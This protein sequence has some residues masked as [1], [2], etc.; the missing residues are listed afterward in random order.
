[1]GPPE[2]CTSLTAGASGQTVLTFLVSNEI[3]TRGQ[4]GTMLGGCVNP[5]GGLFSSCDPSN[6]GDGPT[7]ATVIFRTQVLDEFVD[8]Y[9]SG[10]IS[11]DQGDELGNTA[12]ITGDVLDN[13]TF[14]VVGTE[15]DNAAAGAAIG[16]ETLS[17]S[18]YAI[19]DI[20]N[21]AL[22]D[23]DGLGRVR[24]K[25]G[26]KITYRL[27][28]GL[29]TSDVEELTFDDYFPLPVF[30]V[31]DPDDDGLIGP[32]WSFSSAGGIPTPGVVTL[33]LPGDTFYQYMTD[34]LIGT[35][36]TL[37]AST[38][39]T[40]PT[41]EP[42]IVANA[43][44][45]KINIYFADYDDTRNQSTTVD[46]L[47]SLV[48]S[49]DPFAD[50]LFLT[51]MAHA[52]E[53]STN[54]GTNTENAI[55]QFVLGEPVLATTKGIV[56]TSN[57][58]P[59][60]VFDPT[61]IAPAGVNF[62]DPSNMPRWTGVINSSGLD[63][64]PI[65]S[66]LAGVDAGDTVTFA[67]TIENQGSS[68][69]GAFDIQLRDLI[70]TD[71]YIF[72]LTGADLNLQVYYGDRSGPI[73]YKSVELSAGIPV[74]TSG[75][76]PDC[77]LELFEEGIEFIDPAESNPALAG[78]CSA[79]DPN[80]GNN[81][82]LV[83]YDL[84]L[85]PDVIPG[86]AINTA[87]VFNYPGTEGGPNHL[88]GVDDLE[89]DATVD[90]LGGLEKTLDGTEF[91][92]PTNL[93][94]EV[95]IGELVTYTLTATIPE[96]NVP[97]A[98]LEDHLD[99]GLAFVSCDSVLIT[100]D[101]GVV[102]DLADTDF[103]GVCAATES[104]G[105]SNAGQDIVF[106]LG[107]ISNA[108]RDD[109]LERISITYTVVVTNVIGNQN[110]S[111]TVLNNQ[112]DFLMDAGTGDESLGTVSADEVTVIEPQV[113][114]EKFTPSG[115]TNTSN[116]GDAGDPVSYTINLINPS[117]PADTI[118]YEMEFIDNFPMCP[119]P[120]DGSAVLDLGI[121]SQSGGATFVLTG[122]NTNGWVLS[123]TYNGAPGTPID[124]VP[125]DSATVDLSG[126]IAYCV[127]PSLS[128]DNTGTTTW[129]SLSG[130]FSS[131]S[132][133]PFNPDAVERTGVDGVGGLLNDYA[134]EGTA[135]VMID[136]PINAKYLIDTSEL[137][138][139]FVTNQENV[140]IGEIVRYRVVTAIPE[141]TSPNFQIRDLL[142]QGLVFMNDNTAVVA[143]VSD[144]GITSM[145]VGIVPGI[146]DGPTPPGPDCNQTGSSADASTPVLD[147]VNC[148]LPDFNIGSTSS[149]SAN[150]DI[151][152][153]G[154]D[155]RFKLG[156]LVNTDSD[157]DTEYV[158]IEFNALV[159]N[160]NGDP[161]QNDSSENR[162]NSARIQI[163]GRDNGT[164]SNAVV[165]NIAEPVITVSKSLVAPLPVDAGDPIEYEIIFTNSD[166]TRNGATAFD[167]DL[168]DTFD[169]YLENVT[170]SSVSTTQAAICAGDGAGTTVFSSSQSLPPQ[171]LGGTFNSN[172]KLSG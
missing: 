145:G 3:I 44:D 94:D 162:N 168:T 37:S 14:T 75:V 108:D 113:V 125:G 43:S 150:F 114:T 13:S 155:L 52:F 16:R 46:L 31:T 74:C 65:D 33:M 97:N 138:T 4:N 133:S 88:D 22:W 96:G 95:V 54:A 129:T 123:A 35:T 89:D 166:T 47:F 124:F 48:V 27:T 40:V 19:N 57:N 105:I 107:T 149:T 132:R 23:M 21:S 17:K 90:V 55:I 60:A 144:S 77:G 34:G 86:Q 6:L 11:V 112:A 8:N 161:Q 115:S 70:D 58:N 87:T 146:P 64:D 134:S 72:P 120:T 122:D 56:W 143:F 84:E 119:I 106:N 5:A 29:L 69:R 171:P 148:T 117:T 169:N 73:D 18:I 76:D 53:G 83:T 79:H 159:S 121:D 151:Y 153:P 59:A 66:N 160:I 109:D 1:M 98:R 101:T 93:S 9:P 49:D 158:V 127:T 167:L 71:Y 130:D 36:G 99:S 110:T 170:I 67:I 140:A 92:T 39:N 78:V 61:Q 131:S 85:K 7:T 63:S 41:Q 163:N 15:S 28:Y 2:E 51:N 152:T 103:S 135:S 172:I 50:G 82:I 118:A 116:T 141:G 128:M 147:P 30:D 26:D 142:G 24:V 62:L 137:H 154:I 136:N 164:D 111:P 81:V 32:S 42:V 126:T 139:G 102:T 12:D 20:S 104:T 25:P 68:I 165:V 156:T 157:G 45:N 10:D 91:N 80:L 38:N 100:A